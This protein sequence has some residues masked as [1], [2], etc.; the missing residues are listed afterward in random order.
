MNKTIKIILIILAVLSLIFIVYKIA[1]IKDKP[2]SK[3]EITNYH[4]IYNLTNKPYLDT[5]VE[6]GLISLK[7]DTVTVIIKNIELKSTVINNEDIELKAY[8][9][10]S[11]G[12]YY[13]FIGDYNRSENISILSHE[14]IHLK[15]YYDKT[16]FISRTGV[17]YWL[18]ESIDI[19]DIDYNQRPW[20]IEAFDGE[21]VNSNNMKKIL[22]K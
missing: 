1:T 4:H 17:Y 11:N 6:S 21:S 13:I 2:F 7:I 5:I 18:N 16:L 15:Q 22:Y 19:S 9:V 14:L 10:D 12:I 3:I 20:E 8:I